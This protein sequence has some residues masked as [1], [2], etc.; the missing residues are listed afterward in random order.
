MVD[1][2]CQMLTTQDELSPDSP[3]LTGLAL[4]TRNQ[5]KFSEDG[6]GC[7]SCTRIHKR[8]MPTNW[9]APKCAHT[10]THERPSAYSFINVQR[11]TSYWVA[12]R[13][14]GRGDALLLSES[15]V[16]W[17]LADNYIKAIIAVIRWFPLC[18]LSQLK[19]QTTGRMPSA[20]WNGW[21]EKQRKE[22]NAVKSLIE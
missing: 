19:R 8:H 5:V 11:I 7:W 2:Y 1:R 9:L 20:S 17:L 15:S 14:S 16:A 21:L 12:L 4:D 13:Q 3:P 22:G 6:E 10:D 18:F